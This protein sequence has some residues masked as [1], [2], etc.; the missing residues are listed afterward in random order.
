VDLVACQIPVHDTR[1]VVGGQALD[2]VGGKTR[3]ADQTIVN[4]RP[5]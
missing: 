3:N 4:H 2:N 5:R 1:V